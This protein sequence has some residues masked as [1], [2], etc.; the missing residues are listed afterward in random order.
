[1]KSIEDL[2]FLKDKFIK[3]ENAEHIRAVQCRSRRM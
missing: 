3:E 2:L 1:M